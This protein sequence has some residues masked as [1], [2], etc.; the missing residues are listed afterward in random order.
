[1]FAIENRYVRPV[2]YVVVGLIAA[3]VL[4]F[5]GELIANSRS[6]EAFGITAQTAF[7]V[8]GWVTWLLIAAIGV[9]LLFVWG[10]GNVV[11]RVGSRE[12]V[13]MGLGAA[14]YGTL[15]WIFNAFPVPAVGNVSL[16]PTIIIPIFFGFAFGPVVGFFSGFVGNILGDALTGWGV[17]PNWDVG[18]G[19]VGFIP[20]LIWLFKERSRSVDLL[21][22]L[23]VILL[24][25]AALITRVNPEIT[26]FSGTSV[27]ALWWI[28]AV[29]I[30]LIL[31][32]HYVP[33]LWPFFVGL[34]LAGLAVGAV[35]DL[36]NEG[37]NTGGMVLL[38]I[39]VIGGILTWTLYRR[40]DAIS[41]A[42]SDED[43][44]VLV[45]WGV[46]ANIIGIGF[47]ALSDIWIA[48]LT[49]LVA[50]AGRFVPAAGPNILFAILLAPVLYDAWK[51]ARVRE[52]RQ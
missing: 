12:V 32:I 38:V 18:N 41:A 28:P 40:R 16:R 5:M 29:A 2:P 27:S 30:I 42:L 37:L 21:M 46:M 10:A 26:D 48:G 51:Q 4:L 39:A 6:G 20:G 17:F 25:I 36:V 9:Y 14:L 43:T 34:M 23:T 49:P 45:V 3:F 50:F 11:W 52:G 31:V 1:M 15:S 33:R 19:L 24:G 7:G 44:R 22:W 13:Y 35:V 47:A 8:G